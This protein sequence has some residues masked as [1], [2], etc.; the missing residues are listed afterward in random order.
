[1]I[2]SQ[3]GFAHILFLVLLLLGIIVGVYLVSQRTNLFP[4]ASTS[5]VRL[6]FF[7]QSTQINEGETFNLSVLAEPLGVTPAAVEVKVLFDPAVLQVTNVQSLEFFPVVLKPA[8]ITSGAVSITL[9]N[10]LINPKVGS[11]MINTISFKALKSGTTKVTFDPLTKASILGQVDT[12]NKITEAVES[13]ITITPKSGEQTAQFLL[14]G[15]STVNT[16]VEIPVKLSV[17]SDA[18]LANLFAAKLNFD[19]AKIEVIRID[20]SGTFIKNWVDKSYDN[21]SGKIALVGGVPSP[22]YKTSGSAELLAT[23]YLKGKRSGSTTISFDGTSVIHKNT[24]NLDILK[25]S[26]DLSLN[27]SA[28]LDSDPIP[29]PE[30]TQT[31]IVQDS[32]P[33]TLNSA[34]WEA[35][36]GAIEEGELVRLNV[37]GEGECDQK[38]VEF[39]VVQDKGLLGELLVRN[40]PLRVQFEGNVASSSWVAEYYPDGPFGIFDPAK[41]FFLAK[42]EGESTEFKS[43]GENLKVKKLGSSRFR[44]GD[45]NRNGQIDLQDL[46]ILLSSWFNE[47]SEVS[48]EYSEEV[49]L[50]EDG[51]INA[52]DFSLMSQIL[53][54]EGVIR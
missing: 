37:A 33:C 6:S 38:S 34:N 14:S 31:P 30:P 48:S 4:K 18:D 13:N 12:D 41:Y 16:G 21:Q 10:D 11:G 9:G 8:E 20:D 3:Q 22:G 1:M 39:V 5:G 32:E 17:K 35:Q 24:G 40:N 45:S 23:I 19:P 27:I 46:S 53:E 50:N 28:Y 54:I 51:L 52:F 47:K 42:I 26:L 15:P 44:K 2:K 43:T 49:D 29:P 36:E 25:D 7:P